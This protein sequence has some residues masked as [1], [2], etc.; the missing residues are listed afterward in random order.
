MSRLYPLIIQRNGN[1]TK[2]KRGK[3]TGEVVTLSVR[4][5]VLSINICPESRQ[6]GNPSLVAGGQDCD[7]K[8]LDIIKDPLVL[9]FL[10][11]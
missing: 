4:S 7:E 6:E 5:P 3:A 11:S 1:F 10:G 8:A 9:E 2:L